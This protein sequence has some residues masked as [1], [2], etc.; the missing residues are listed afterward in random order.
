MR[1]SG[2]LKPRSKAW[3]D[4]ALRQ[5]G[6]P[7]RLCLQRGQYE[8]THCLTGDFRTPSFTE[9]SRRKKH[10]ATDEL[11]KWALLEMDRVTFRREGGL[12]DDFRHGRVGVD[13]GVDLVDGELLVE[14]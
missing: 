7:P 13:G 11:S 14:G 10:G 3:S 5:V 6:C 2:K 4:I 1:G 12:V 9:R 8:C